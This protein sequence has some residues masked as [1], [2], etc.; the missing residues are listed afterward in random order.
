M[1]ATR[2]NP[3]QPVQIPIKTPM[4]VFLASF[5]DTALLR[6]QF[7]DAPPEPGRP[8]RRHPLL[9]RTRAC[10]LSIL[11]GRPPEA[12]PPLDLSAGTPFQQSVWETMRKIPCGQTLS[13]ADVARAIGRPNATR[14]VGV[15]CGRNP[16]PVIVPCHRVVGALGLGGFS[17]GLD[18]KI[19]LLQIEG[20]VLT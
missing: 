8:A 19:R 16:V 5:S 6:L 3:P 20:A 11:R 14:A 10:L 9:A 12:F 2:S 15:A 4:G 18:W 7:P 1:P 13:Y 17:S